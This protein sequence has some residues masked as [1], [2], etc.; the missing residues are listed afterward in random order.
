[1][2]REAASALRYTLRGMIRVCQLIHE[3]ITIPDDA[4]KRFRDAATKFT[5]DAAPRASRLL[6]VKDDI[7]TLAQKGCFIPHYRLAAYPER[8]RCVEHMRDAILSQLTWGETC[9]QR[10]TQT[11]CC[12]EICVGCQRPCCVIRSADQSGAGHFSH[13]SVLTTWADARRAVSSSGKFEKSYSPWK[14]IRT[15][16]IPAR[17]FRPVYGS[18]AP[19]K[20]VRKMSL[21]LRAGF[22]FAAPPLTV[23]G[24]PRR[25]WLGFAPGVLAGVFSS[26]V[27]TAA[28]GDEVATPTSRD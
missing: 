9:P 24:E 16:S 7:A 26:Y 3:S 10:K 11:C 12:A 5:R 6:A 18:P 15:G 27:F 1:M 23:L 13:I 2:R 4:L 17:L 25:G 20:V 19:V 14:C 21:A 22:F 8:H 28:D